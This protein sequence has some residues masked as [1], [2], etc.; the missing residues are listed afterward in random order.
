MPTCAWRCSFFDVFCLGLSYCVVLWL[1]AVETLRAIQRMTQQILYLV[2]QCVSVFVC[3]VYTDLHYHVHVTVSMSFHAGMPGV[4]YHWSFWFITEQT[5]N[6]FLISKDSKAV[7]SIRN[8]TASNA[9]LVKTH[10]AQTRAVL[11]YTTTFLRCQ[12]YPFP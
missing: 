11:S 6:Q 2:C 1:K 8:R 12:C 5:F 9:L 10:T 4:R 3:L 7:V